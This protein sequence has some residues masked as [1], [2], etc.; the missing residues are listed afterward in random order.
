MSCRPGG[1]EV[2]LAHE[3]GTRK[4]VDMTV[5]NYDGLIPMGVDIS[6]VDP[7]STKFHRVRTPIAAGAAAKDRE[8]YKIKK[9]QDAYVS[10]H[11]LFEPF[12][13]ESF[14]RFGD[15]TRAL[16]SQVVDR[17]CAIKDQHAAAYQKPYWKARIVMALHI[18]ACNG[19]KDRMDGVLARRGGLTVGVESADSRKRVDCEM[20]ARARY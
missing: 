3:P 4:S 2:C 16:F 11:V 1:R 20:F 18:N 7:R 9:Y 6:V 10:Q 14:G 8:V 15:G 5:D 13:L 19:V 12:V 17:I